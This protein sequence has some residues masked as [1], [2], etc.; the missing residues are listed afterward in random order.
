MKT[1][2]NF[3][4]TIII[5][6]GLSGVAA[7]YHLKEN[8]PDRTF[9]ILESRAAIGGTW[10]LFKYPGVR[11]D[12]DMYT[13][14]FSF[15]PWKNPKSI[16]D[17][18]DILEYIN[19]TVDNF[20][21][22]EA[23]QFNKKASTARW[24]SVT[25]QWTLEVY[26]SLTETTEIIK[27]NFLFMCS[28][29]YNYDKG[30]EPDFPNATAFKGVKVHPQKWDASLDYTDKKVVIIGSGATAVTLLPKLAEKA[31]QVTMLQRSPTYIMNMPSED[32]IAN[33]L[34]KILPERLAH[35]IIRWKNILISMVFYLVSKRFPKFIKK[36]LKKGIKKEL[37]DKY[38]EQ[39]FNPKY[40]PWDQR[41]CLVPDNDLFESLK[42]KNAEIVTDTIASFTPEGILLNSGMTL[43]ADI[44]VTATGLNLQLFG[45]MKLIVDDEVVDTSKTHAYKGVMLSGVP[46]FAVALGYTN[47]SWTLKCDLNCLFVVKVLNHMKAHNYTICTPE[48][49]HENLKSEP[50]LDFDAGYVLRA[51][52]ILPKQ[53]SKA[54]WKVHQN[55]LKDLSSLKYGSVSDEYL[56]YK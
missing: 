40:F 47:A 5:G 33:F 8:C 22:R 41:L 43:T 28:G 19:D 18:N 38:D 35:N 12:S 34:K 29:Y 17:G 3:Y 15:N 52:H 21:I 11:S 53:G 37:G 45:G 26:N 23:I 42:N 27:C 9:S 32:A 54:P 48:F 7:A 20:G 51:N 2:E 24:S 16:A 46:N 31:E 44:I 56:V 1:N 14:G 50:L 13:L 10:D 30:Y 49:D 6:A 25:N 4:D 39:N 36:V 55:Y